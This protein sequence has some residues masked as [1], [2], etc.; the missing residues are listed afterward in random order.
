VALLAPADG[1]LTGG[2]A[3]C[4]CSRRPG[5][6]PLRP[7]PGQPLFS[8]GSASKPVVGLLRSLCSLMG[9][10]QAQNLPQQ[11]HGC[12]A[13][14]RAGGAAAGPALRPAWR[15][16]GWRLELAVGGGVQRD[17]CW[18]RPTVSPPLVQADRA[19]AAPRERCLK[20]KAWYSNHSRAVLGAA[21]A[22]GCYSV[23]GR[24]KQLR[25]RLVICLVAVWFDRPPQ[26]PLL[27]ELLRRLPGGSH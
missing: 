3:W 19:R 24:L 4:C 7:W 22:G 26:W 16:T 23:S 12:G 1:L 21:A 5:D 2:P 11:W 6:R 20:A 9:G 18:A 13:A 8:W 14:D 10:L 27:F 25:Y 15:P 17:S